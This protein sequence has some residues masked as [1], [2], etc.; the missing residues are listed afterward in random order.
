[1][2]FCVKK[3]E[4]GEIIQLSVNLNLLDEHI[5]AQWHLFHLVTIM[6]H[7]QADLPYNG[8]DKSSEPQ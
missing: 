8:S 2:K 1:M 3:V 6:W 5:I 4:T 7:G